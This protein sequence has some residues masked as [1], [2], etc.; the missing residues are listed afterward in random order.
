[1]KVREGILPAM[2]ARIRWRQAVEIIGI[3]G[4][5][6]RRWRRRYEADG[7]DGLRD[8]RRGRVS[9]KRVPLGIVEAVLTLFQE[10]YFAHVESM[11]Q[12]EELKLWTAVNLTTLL[13]WSGIIPLS[14]SPV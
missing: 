6:V 9:E 8:R 7:Y 4:R 11:I 10:Q 5:Q 14:G 13:V 3:N 12:I 1:M 2:A